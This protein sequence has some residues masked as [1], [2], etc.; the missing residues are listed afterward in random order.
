MAL[1]QKN[2]C[3][4]NLLD[5]SDWFL[6]TMIYFVKLKTHLSEILKPQSLFKLQGAELWCWVVMLSWLTV[7]YGL[8]RY[9]KNSTVR[10][11]ALYHP[12]VIIPLKGSTSHSFA[13]PFSGPLG[14]LFASRY[15]ETPSI[16]KLR[17]IKTHASRLS[18]EKKTCDIPWNTAWFIGTFI[19]VYYNSQQWRFF[20]CSLLLWLRLLKFLD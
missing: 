15:S 13:P 17:E 11:D 5:L 12:G 19:M 3:S 20:H 8:R 4:W 16:S 1:L 7:S 6:R 10:R 14:S 18:N 2:S 9:V